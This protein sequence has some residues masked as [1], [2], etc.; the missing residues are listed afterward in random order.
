MFCNISSLDILNENT[1][2]KY[3]IQFDGDRYTY[4]NHPIP[5][6]TEILSSMLHEDYLMSWSNH[7]GLYQH[8]EY[9]KFLNDAANK[10]TIVHESI[11]NY[12]KN[13]IDLDIETV[14]R[15]YRYQVNNAFNSFKQWWD[16]ISKH[17]VQVLFQEEKLVCE[18][19]GGTLDM[20]IKIDGSIYLVDFKTSNHPS[21]KYF[22]QMSAYQHILETER[23]IKIDGVIILMLNKT[24]V[25]FKEYILNFNIDNNDRLFMN[26]CR[27]AFLSLVYS[28]YNRLY[29]ENM[30]NNRFFK[31]DN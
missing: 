21:Y 25:G 23:N 3:D 31:E 4:N 22:L 19:F 26:Y 18:W 7:I 28:Y 6:V 2:D 20:L 16:I 27:E 13:D 10:G 5:R 29:I 8:K 15:E 11:E 14:P 9:E 30:Y 1:Y 12:V 24:K 17:D